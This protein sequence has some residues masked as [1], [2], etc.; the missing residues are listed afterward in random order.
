V[1]TD[2]DRKYVYVVG[3]GNWPSAATSRWVAWSM[4]G[5]WWKGLAG[6][7]LVVGGVQRIYY[8]GMPVNPRPGRRRWPRRRP[9]LRSKGSAMDFSKFFIDRPIFAVALHHHVRRRPGGHSAAAGG[10]ISR[11]RAAVVVRA[12]YPGANPKEVA[13]SVAVPLE[14]INGVEGLM[15]M[16]SVAA[17]DGSLQVVATFRP[18]S[19]PTP[20]P[21]ACRTASA[22]RL[23]RGGAAVRRDHA[24]AGVHAADVRGPG[25]PRRQ[26]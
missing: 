4:A 2:Q 24:E 22:R 5:A 3:E 1:L 19:T 14:E 15:Y 17:S 21:C 11:G 12:T 25:L 7:R 10:R 23:A 8:P 16:K 26:P 6:D 13:E 9:W 18:K 20:P